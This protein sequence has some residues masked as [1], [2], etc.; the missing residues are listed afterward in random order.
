MCPDC[1]ELRRVKEIFRDGDKP[2][3]IHLV[4]GHYRGELLR[5]KAGRISLENLNSAL[6]R[7]LFPAVQMNEWTAP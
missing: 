4:C 7:E 3:V 6:G 2:T 5:L 1:N